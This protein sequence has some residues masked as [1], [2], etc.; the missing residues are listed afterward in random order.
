M[1]VK[2]AVFPV[3]GLGSR[4]LPATKANPKEMLPVVDK[5]LIQYAVEE[6]VRAGITHMIFIT[7]SSKRAIEDHF[8]NHFELETRLREQ[9]K[10]KLLALVKSISPPGIQFSYVR[11]HQPL[12]LGHAI[13]SAEHAIG[14]EPFAVL[15][16]DDLIDDF[17]FPCLSAMANHFSQTGRSV[18]AVQPVPWQE[19][20][21][22]GVV[23]TVDD[24]RSF[25]RISDMIE[26]PSQENAPS[27]LA[28][29]GRYIF[30]PEIF[31]CLKDTK[32]DH[33]G[34]IQLTGGIQRLLGIEPVYAYRFGGKRYDCG[35]KLGYLLATVEF[36][37][38]HE[39]VG[40]AFR[41]FLHQ[42][43][44]TREFDECI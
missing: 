3:A 15:L 38:R 29:V 33:R 9:G 35:S 39:E 44:L 2:K 30:T 20:H 42:A 19:I 23:K 7:S 28:A 21:Q 6:A 11:Q 34:E 4:F 1:Q 41:D 14:D 32:I 22:Y 10:E 18:L 40:H 8:D 31:P 12:G 25:M 27:N 5:P 43:N 36:G 13:L 26:K 16:A 24:T 37:M 17:N